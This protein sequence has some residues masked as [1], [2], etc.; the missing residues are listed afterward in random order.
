MG[1]VNTTLPM[2]LIIITENIRSAL[3]NGKFACGI[4][5]DLQKAF[6]TVNHIILLKKLEHYGIRGIGNCWF[7][8]YLDNRSQFVSISGF[9]SMLK[10]IIHS[11]PRCSVL[12]PFL[13]LL[14]VNDL[15]DAIK[16]MVHH[17]ADD[18]NLLLFDS[19][20]KSLQK[21]LTLI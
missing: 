18:T 20:L 11:V 15:H 13:F 17:S 5:V 6:D 9:D 4:F 14:Y 16:Y 8:S 7:K 3:N 10:S 1:F 19:S 12:G 2:T 21:K